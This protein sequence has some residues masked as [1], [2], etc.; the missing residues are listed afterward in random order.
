VVALELACPFASHPYGID[1]SI[2]LTFIG[3]FT[4]LISEGVYLPRWVPEAFQG[5]GSSSFYFYPPLAFYMAAVVKLLT[6]STSTEFLFQS[7]SIIATVGSFFTSGILFRALGATRYQ[8]HLGAIL[9]AVAPFRVAE[10]YTR[11]DLPAHVGYIFLP[12]VAFGLVRIVTGKPFSRMGSILLLSISL[13]SVAL[14]NVPLI[15]W[16]V[17]SIGFTAIAFGRKVTPKIFLDASMASILAAGLTAFHYSSV[18]AARPYAELGDLL[19]LQ[20]PSLFFSLGNL[21][22]IYHLALVLIPIALAAY[23]YLRN[24]RARSESSNLERSIVRIGIACAIPIAFLSVPYW[25]DPL[26]QA[27]HWLRLLQAGWR[28]YIVLVL[29]G[30]TLLAVARSSEMLRATRI[31]VWVWVIGAMGPVL[32]VLLNLQIGERI[33]EPHADPT[34]YRPI[35]TIAR[36]RIAAVLTPHE[37]DPAILWDRR[38]GEHID[39]V[40]YAP[41]EEGFNVS[42]GSQRMATFHRF[43]WPGWNL[44]NSNRALETSFDSIGRAT[45]ILPAGNYFL[46]WRLEAFPLERTGRC[47]SLLSLIVTLLCTGSLFFNNGCRK[48]REVQ[49]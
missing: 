21:R 40:S 1:G 45:A 19:H 5:F 39:R 22:N 47:V 8:Q 30:S 35:H 17:L 43:H 12:L 37:A 9:Y 25:S 14:C 33:L 32:I 41:N 16:T 13:A 7:V 4:R 23:A 27:S 10:L 24:R 34:E 48:Q 28:S 29:I 2:H 20:G 49:I 6:G 42:L 26:W 31:I 44:Y 36:E 15:L 38:N 3:E 46:R 18:L 11:S